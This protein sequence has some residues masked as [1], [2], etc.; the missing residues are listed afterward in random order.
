MI[1]MIEKISVCG[2]ILYY[3]Y[4]DNIN[5]CNSKIIISK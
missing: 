5:N 4:Y 3:H 2:I 1:K